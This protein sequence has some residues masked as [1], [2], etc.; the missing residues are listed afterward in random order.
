MAGSRSTR[1][2]TTAIASQIEQLQ[3]NAN[4]VLP[5]VGESSAQGVNR[6]AQ[7][8]DGNIFTFSNATLD[9]LP[10]NQQNP[11]IKTTNE[12]MGGSIRSI[13]TED[14]KTNP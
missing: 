11:P 1:S 8:N 13:I 7:T 5:L 2:K 4:P 14:Q 6:Q 9:V 10:L 3:S 12:Q